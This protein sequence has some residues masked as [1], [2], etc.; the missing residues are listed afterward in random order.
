MKAGMSSF[1]PGLQ[2][3]C[4]AALPHGRTGRTKWEVHK[5][6]VNGTKDY[7]SGRAGPEEH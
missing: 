1:S 6:D 4:A 3:R 2:S 5:Q 7:L